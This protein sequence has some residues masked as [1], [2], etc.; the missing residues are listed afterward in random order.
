[1]VKDPA[2]DR[3]ENKKI[4]DSQPRGRGSVKALYEGVGITEG[5][6]GS[7]DKAHREER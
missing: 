1:M 3:R 7:Q 5:K 4:N 6:K 2:E